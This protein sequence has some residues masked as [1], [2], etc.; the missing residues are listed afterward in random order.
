M[1]LATLNGWQRDEKASDKEALKFAV[2]N[3][4]ELRDSIRSEEGA[5]PVA[6]VNLRSLDKADP[7]VKYFKT[8][9]KRVL[10]EL[11]VEHAEQVKGGDE[12]GKQKES[13]LRKAEGED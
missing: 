9:F 7:K 10:R 6:V 2:A 11:E 12:V 1:A 5:V 13:T 8:E 4:S 3:V